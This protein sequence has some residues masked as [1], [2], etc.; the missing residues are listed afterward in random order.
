MARPGVRGPGDLTLAATWNRAVAL[1]P[2]IAVTL[3]CLASW[4]V[5]AAVPLPIVGLTDLRLG[6]GQLS[7][8][9]GPLALLL[10]G[11]LERE[12]VVAMGL[13][14]FL[15][16]FVLFW[17][18][19]ALT[20]N[21][22]MAQTD[23][24]RMWRYLAWLTAG[25]AFLRAFGLTRL[26]L[27]GQ[28]GAVTSSAG[29]FSLFGLLL[30]TMALFGLGYVIDRFGEPAGYGVWFMFGVQSLM[31][32]THRVAGWVARDAG[33]SS[34]GAILIAYAVISVLLLASAYL[35][36]QGVR[37]VA[38]RHRGSKVSRA[39]PTNIR[40][41]LPGGGVIVPIVLASFAV[42]F[43]PTMVLEAIFRLSNQ[44][45]TTYWSAASHLPLVAIGYQVAFFT[46]IVL[47]CLL[48]TWQ[49][50]DAARVAGRFGIR[51]TTALALF[52]GIWMGLAVVVAPLL[53]QLALGPSRPRLPVGGGPFV[54][55]AAI[56]ITA[57][58]RLRG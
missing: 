23:T 31:E 25:L 24:S 20:G 21:L 15:D 16:A 14:P 17:V 58:Q 12:S 34:F 44:Q 1:W 45:V 18:W 33:D 53:F 3:I 55:A 47:A 22:G 57:T 48:T 46:L 26:F 38:V 27:G 51:V 19:A 28:P 11:P 54:I 41:H 42:S 7:P 43:V 30:G 50:M 8:D 36:L 13:N 29:L 2:R 40:L 4:R 9:R 49:T 35:V 10:G 52:G 37:D 32:G 56:F 39:K 5:L 6:S